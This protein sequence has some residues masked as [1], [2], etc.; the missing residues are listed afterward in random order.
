MKRSPSL[1]RL[2]A[3]ALLFTAGCAGYHLGPTAGQVAGARSIQI[4]PFVNR[5]LEPRLSQ[6]VMMSLRKNLMQDGTYRLDTHDEGDVILTGEI[7]TYQRNGLSFQPTDV[8]TVLDYEIT[9]TAQITARE[10]NT[11]KVIFDKAVIGKTTLRAGPDLTSAERQAIPLLTDDLAK[12]TT[13][14]LVEGNW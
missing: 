4:A 13:A 9:M 3:L 14:L 12:K 2:C 10:R 1:W 6:Y 7:K 8:L 11:G 5:T